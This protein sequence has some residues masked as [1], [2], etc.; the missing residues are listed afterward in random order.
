MAT[1]ERRFTC[2]NCGETVSPGCMISMHIS[3]SDLGEPERHFCGNR[4]CIFFWLDS[5]RE[6]LLKK[7]L[8]KPEPA[9]ESKTAD[10]AIDGQESGNESAES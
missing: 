6:E 5:R 7:L 1:T 9:G 8:P 2:D 4:E 3:R 10:V